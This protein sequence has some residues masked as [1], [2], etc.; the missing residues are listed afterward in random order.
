MIALTRGVSPSIVR[1]ELTHLAREP[2]DVDRAR[3]QHCAYE[4]ALMRLG[5]S[6]QR[7]PGGAELP[8]AV[9]IEDTAVV[10]PEIAI[11][12]RPGAASRRSE[13]DAVAAALAPLRDLGW[14]EEPATLDGGDVLVVGTHVFVGRSSRTTDSGV[15]QLRHVLE[16]MGYR[17]TAVDTTGCLHLKS[18]ACALSANAVVINPRWVPIDLFERFEVVEID[19]SEPHAA[20]IV[21]LGNGPV[22]A[23]EAF[24]RTCA[25]LERRGFEVIRVDVSELAK[26]EGALTCCSLLVT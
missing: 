4:D 6:V 9:F 22:M 21:S 10:L 24:P 5:Y 16:P 23:S 26:A 19:P 1:C 17:L 3:A 8:D 20:N 25:R 12:A 18:A 7:V 2:I 11:M 13:V 14:I 15:E